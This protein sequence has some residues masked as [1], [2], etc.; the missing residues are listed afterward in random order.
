VTAATAWAWCLASSA[1]ARSSALNRSAISDRSRSSPVNRLFRVAICRRMSSASA[2]VWRP[3][4]CRLSAA[5]SRGSD[6]QATH[7]FTGMCPTAGIETAS[8]GVKSG[9][10]ERRWMFIGACR[11]VCRATSGCQG[12]RFTPP[13]KTRLSALTAPLNGPGRSSPSTNG[14]SGLGKSGRTM[15]R[16]G[17][18]MMPTFPSSPLRFRTAGFPSVR[19]QSWPI[20]QGLP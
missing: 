15:A 7:H 14:K 17:L 3:F 5:A 16:T 18:R 13:H 11:Q 9:A 10:G 12:W 6:R 4:L 1:W 8:Q 2:I 19:L 20:R